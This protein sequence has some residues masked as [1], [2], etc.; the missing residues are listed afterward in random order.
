MRRTKRE[1][2]R[3]VPTDTD[4]SPLGALLALALVALLLVVL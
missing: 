2:G 4:V 3:P 1:P